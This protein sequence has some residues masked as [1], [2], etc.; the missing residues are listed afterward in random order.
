MP[1]RTTL[2]AFASIVIAIAITMV[3]M[4]WWAQAVLLLVLIS[5]VIDISFHG[6]LTARLGGRAKIGVCLVS[7]T[8]ILLIGLR[9]VFHQYHIE[10]TPE[11]LRAS[12][13]I[14]VHEPNSFSIEYSFANEGRQPA[15][16]NSIGLTSVMANNRTEEPASNINLCENHNSAKLLV[17]HLLGLLGLSQL[18]NE[19]IKKETYGPKEIMVDGGPWPS[20]T[21]ISVEGGKSRTLSATYAIDPTDQAKYNV[22][23]LCPVVEAYD[24]I[25]LGGTAVC[26]GLVSTRTDTGLVSIRAA[27]RVRI[28]PRTRDVLCPSA[29]Q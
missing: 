18:A 21:T 11:D 9:S 17:S 7:A 3:S 26:R 4:P 24:D 27:E 23:A 10:T 1:E 14:E 22:I 8:V 12:F 29:S 13:F 20:G 16:I 2:E 6:P 15:S 19:S 28:L 5:F 25:G